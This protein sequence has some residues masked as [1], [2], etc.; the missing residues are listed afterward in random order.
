MI[1]VAAL[2]RSRDYMLCDSGRWKWIEPL[3]VA[4]HSVIYVA[5]H[6]SAL[7]QLQLQLA[8][9]SI[10][11][12][13]LYP[14]IVATTTTSQQP[15]IFRSTLPAL[16]HTRRTHHDPRFCKPR[17]PFMANYQE[18][19]ARTLGSTQEEEAVTVNTRALVQ[20]F[21]TYS[22]LYELMTVLNRSTK[23]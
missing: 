18:L 16:Q 15:F 20:L 17:N 12:P 3:L 2:T 1:P 19:R 9:F 10:T 11:L 5:C 22:V 14:T 8:S 4:Y 13:S 7:Q 23:F 6:P 21:T